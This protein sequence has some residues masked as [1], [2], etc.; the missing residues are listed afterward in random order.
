MA[1]STQRSLGGF[2]DFLRRS[3][4][5]ELYSPDLL[6]DYLSF[7]LES[8]IMASPDGHRWA[9][10]VESLERCQAMGGAETHLKLLKTIALVDLFKERSGLSSNANVLKLSLAPRSMNTLKRR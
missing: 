2:Q 5:D 1:F 9:L 8:S 10:A 6:W 4:D 3:Q 7:N